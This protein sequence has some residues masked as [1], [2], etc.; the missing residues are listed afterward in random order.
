MLQDGWSRYIR[1]VPL[2][3]KK[4]SEIAKNLMDHFISL[5]GCPLRIHSDQGPEFCSA[6]FK[7]L[8]KELEIGKTTTP[9][10]NPN[11]NLVERFH[12]SLNQMLRTFM[13]RKDVEWDVRL[14]A[15][16]LAYNTKVNATTG[17]TP[18]LA[19]L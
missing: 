14:P 16:G 19:F 12:K 2:K 4:S 9:T 7:D 18:A 8:L 11:S 10:Y 17:V 1:L 13:E 6:L 5:F 15:I 3:T